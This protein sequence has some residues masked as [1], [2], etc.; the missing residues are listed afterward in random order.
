MKLYGRREHFTAFSEGARTQQ[1]HLNSPKFAVRKKKE[2]DFHRVTH[3]K[4]ATSIYSTGLIHAKV[5]LPPADMLASDCRRDE[6][7]G[8]HRPSNN[9]NPNCSLPWLSLRYHHFSL[10][11]DPF[12]ANPIAKKINKRNSHHPSKTTNEFFCVGH[13]KTPSWTGVKLSKGNCGN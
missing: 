3:P 11:L 5:G 13:K 6:A 4:G 2:K 10:H 1:S 12:A 8:L 9:N 7:S